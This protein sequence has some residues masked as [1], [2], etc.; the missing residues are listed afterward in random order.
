MPHAAPLP[1]Q[2]HLLR[3]LTCL[4]FLIFAMTTDA[5]GVILPE[6]IR[7]YGLSMAA[8]SAFHYGTMLAI[9]LSGFLLGGLADRL[10]RKF[11]I[12]LGL[13]LFSLASGMF[14]LGDGFGFFLVLLML[15]G[16]AVG[17]FKTGALALIGDLSRSTREHTA[18]MNTVEGF[19]AIG[20]IVGPALV[21]WLLHTGLPWKWLYLAAAVLAMVLVI[22]AASVRYPQPPVSVVGAGDTIAAHEASLRQCFALMRQPYVLGFALSLFMYVA[23]E[24]AIYVWLPTLLLGYKGPSTWLAAYALPVFFAL[25][26]LGRFLGGWLLSRVEW[27][28]LICAM[29]FGIALCFLVALWGGVAWA[30]YLLPASGLFM[31]VLYPTLNSKGISCAPRAQHGAVAGFNLFFSCLA[32]AAGPFAMGLVADAFGGMRYGFALASAFAV[33]LFAGLLWNWLRQPVREYLARCDER[34]YAG[35]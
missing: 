11:T 14:A 20:A 31:S 1:A 10:G 33:V 9:A 26:A 24:C 30:V 28:L 4:M 17:I 2:T 12:L 5:V 7:T 27:T 16:V 32:A 21:T 25:R 22:S 35:A 18:T 23:V 8:A 29:S 15:S 19:F 34:D 3:W 13:A 6:V